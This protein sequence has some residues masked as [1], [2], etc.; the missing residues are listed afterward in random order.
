[1]SSDKIVV[2]NWNQL[3]PYEF[4]EQNRPSDISKNLQ[5]K[6]YNEMKGNVYYG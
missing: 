2:E 3:G 4:D 5:W 1:M 6:V